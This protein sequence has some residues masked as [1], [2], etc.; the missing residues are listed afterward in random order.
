MSTDATVTDHLLAFIKKEAEQAEK[1][2]SALP[3]SAQPLWFREHM[4]SKGQ[5]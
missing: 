2:L 3:E 5:A 4:K 1:E